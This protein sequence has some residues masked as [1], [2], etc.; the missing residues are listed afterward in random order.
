MPP[1]SPTE[2][3]E[4]KLVP[5]RLLAPMEGVP[6][7][8]QRVPA[9][10]GFH[11]RRVDPPVVLD[12]PSTPEAAIARKVGEAGRILVDRCRPG[13]QRP[14]TGRTGPGCAALGGQFRAAAGPAADAD[15]HDAPP[16][17][18]L[19]TTG[20]PRGPPP[21]LPPPTATRPRPAVSSEG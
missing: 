18:P 2:A 3:P 19:D 7:L 4:V 16:G 12:A 5:L 1:K 8:L 14:A 11:L 13:G 21:L 6:R 10:A 9:D 20:V 15:G 17:H